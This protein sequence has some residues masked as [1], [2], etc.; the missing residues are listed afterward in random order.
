M[1]IAA[2]FPSVRATAPRA[3]VHRTSAHRPQPVRLTRRGRAVIAAGVFLAALAG[4][5]ATGPVAD[6]ASGASSGQTAV[7]VVQPGQTV[8]SIAKTLDPG[9]DPRGLV[10]RI[11]ELNGLDDAVVV[12]GQALVVPA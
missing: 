8:W 11:R 12:P 10:G 9:A 7:V 5:I 1:A 6:A 3:R 4:L 2:P